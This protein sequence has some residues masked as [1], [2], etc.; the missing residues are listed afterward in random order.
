MARIT[1]PARF[2]S[3]ST[4]D[5]SRFIHHSSLIN[6][7]P[8]LLIQRA[9]AGALARWFKISG[10]D[11]PWRR[12]TDPYPILVSEIM[13]Q[14]TQITTVLDRGYYDRWMKRFPDFAT[15]AKA[16]E[17]EI[18]KAWE[19]LGYYRRARFLHKLAQTVVAAHG[20]IFPRDITAIR[21]L[22]GIGDYTAG[23]VASFAFNDKQ[24]IVDGNIA[25][26]L[27]RIFNDVTP[28]DSTAGKKL[29]WQRATILVRASASARIHNSALMELGQ[30]VCKSA[31]PDCKSCPVKKFCAATDPASLPVKSKRTQITEVIEHVYFQQTAAGVLLEQETGSRR[32]GLWKLPALPVMKRLPKTLHTSTYTITRYRVTLHVHAAPSHQ[33]SLPSLHHS[34]IPLSDLTS[35]PMPSPY[36]RVLEALVKVRTQ[37]DGITAGR[38]SRRALPA[39]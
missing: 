7:N 36:R 3:L 16:S 18:L 34:M 19:G 32:T 27:S 31:T 5:N 8:P 1:G 13:L 2:D 21:K 35:L 20:G 38:A 37:R 29:L 17:H 10:R 39:R 6:H 24:P 12:T 28:V 22:P 33:I 25:R 30:T 23:A 4:L 11:Y 14:Q 15:L 26:V 9:F